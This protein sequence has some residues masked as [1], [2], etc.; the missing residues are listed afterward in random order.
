MEIKE[1]DPVGRYVLK[2]TV[3][4][5]W[6]SVYDIVYIL[7]SSFHWNKRVTAILNKL[8]TKKNTPKKYKEYVKRGKT[9]KTKGDYKRFNF[10]ELR[11]HT[12]FFCLKW[13]LLSAFQKNSPV[14]ITCTPNITP[15]LLR[16]NGI[17]SFYIIEIIIIII[18]TTSIIVIPVIIVVI[19][20]INNIIVIIIAT[21]IRFL[22]S[23]LKTRA[24]LSSLPL[25]PSS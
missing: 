9:E 25:S 19:F 4:M 3:F 13:L 23:F 8:Q 6:T 2:V 16:L 15:S 20:I 24:A 18:T 7:L 1:L 11:N 17:I 14:K 22:L 12:A 21:N 10:C 5:T